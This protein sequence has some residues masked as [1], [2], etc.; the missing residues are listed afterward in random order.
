NNLVKQMPQFTFG[1]LNERVLINNILTEDVALGQLEVEFGKRGIATVTFSTGTSLRDFKRALSLLATKPKLIE[2]KGGIKKFVEHNVIPGVRVLP[3]RTLA[4]EDKML[5]M[6]AESYLMAE[7]I[8]GPQAGSGAQG[9]E[10]FRSDGRGGVVVEINSAHRHV[11]SV[12]RK[13]S[14]TPSIP[15]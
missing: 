14:R 7:G 12:R 3:A 15:A 1:F 8:L 2:E 11:Q 6:D 10:D 4:G 13:S 5:A 9:F